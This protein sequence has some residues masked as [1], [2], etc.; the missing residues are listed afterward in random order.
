MNALPVVRLA[1]ALVLSAGI[2]TASAASPVEPVN[3]NKDSVAIKGYDPV[4]YFT[5]SK[6]VKGSAQFT[7]EWKG[8]KWQFA[9]EENR[10]LFKA[11]PDK[12]APQYGGY[13]AWAVGHN[14]TADTD[15]EAWKIVDGKLYLN[16]NKSVQ[17]KWSQEMPKW[18]ADGDKNWPSLHK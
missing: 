16:Y 17:A 1:F 3:K 13:C 9:S 5:Q 8:A 7:H 15:P 6:P 11:S 12:Y 2:Y 14:Y 4:A 10:N 18:I